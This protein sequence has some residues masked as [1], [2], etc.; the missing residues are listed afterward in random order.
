MSQFVFIFILH[1]NNS[2]LDKKIRRSKTN[3]CMSIS[4]FYVGCLSNTRKR[5]YRA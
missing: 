4:K 5:N 1:S 2:I 3:I